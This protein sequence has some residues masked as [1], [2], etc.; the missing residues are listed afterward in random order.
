ML[1]PTKESDVIWLLPKKSVLALLIDEHLAAQAM[2]PQQPF[3]FWC[4]CLAVWAQRAH[5]LA[6]CMSCI[7][8]ICIVL[9][10]G[11][12][13]LADAKPGKPAMAIARQS[14]IRRVWFNARMP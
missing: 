14:I 5:G 3:L 9:I 2:S 8:E 4:S 10:I 12:C 7:E 13:A 6:F 11:H 1:V